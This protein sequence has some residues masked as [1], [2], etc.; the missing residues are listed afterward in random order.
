MKPIVIAHRGASV[1]APE[2]TVLAFEKA[3]EQDCDMIEIDVHAT[4][5][6]GLAVIHDDT[7]D[8][9]TDRKGRVCD[10]TFEELIDVDAGEGQRIPSLQQVIDLVTGK[11]GLVVELKETG[12]ERK[13]VEHLSKSSITDQVIVTSFFHPAVRQVKSLFPQVRTAV[14]TF[15][16][17]I[18]ANSL[19]ANARADALWIF[20]RYVTLEMVASAHKVGLRLYVWYV[21]DAD[22]MR[23][24]LGLGVDGILTGRPNTLREII[25][26]L[27]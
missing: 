20:R 25:T 26:N 13:V 11:V 12:L 2:N 23:R 4:K 8:R 10:F 14:I 6:G 9:T 3:I 21:N 16:K 19:A 17:P 27:G 18:E 22:E 1:Y 24:I 5:D 15:S 7:L